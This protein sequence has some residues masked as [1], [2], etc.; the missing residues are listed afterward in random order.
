MSGRT[1]YEILQVSPTASD[2]EIKAAYR[3]L[4]W[5]PTGSAN[6][7]E[8]KLINEAYATLSSPHRRATYDQALA[9]GTPVNPAPAIRPPA[10]PPVT[11]TEPLPKGPLPLRLWG[12]VTGWVWGLSR[13]RYYFIPIT[14]VFGV[15]LIG[16]FFFLLSE[17]E[18][19]TNQPTP[20]RTSISILV[21]G[22]P[23]HRY[24]TVAGIPDYE[25]GYTVRG[26]D[27]ADYYV[28]HDGPQ[29][30]F[31]TGAKGRPEGNF[32]GLI[33]P[34]DS[35][36][37]N[38]I[39]KDAQNDGYWSGVRLLTT[40]YLDTTYQPKPPGVY[41]AG[42]GAVVLAL[43]L[44]IVP[45]IGRYTVFVARDGRDEEPAGG[46]VAWPVLVEATGKFRPVQGR[47]WRHF[48]AGALAQMVPGPEAGSGFKVLMWLIN[49]KNE[50]AYEIHI[51]A[52]SHVRVGVEY[53]GGRAT[54][55]LAVRAPG[56]TICLRLKSMAD[57][58]R[59]AQAISG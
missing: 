36:L 44:L 33:R 6:Q 43:L 15:F 2:E 51:P 11:E 32:T 53:T 21:R 49:G 42:M 41:M 26:R 55:A 28:L 24:I 27:A 40:H 50:K 46:E 34:L 47:G 13:A 48:H 1:L 58:H 52:G 56:Q 7:E 29:V 9:E 5:N 57:A 22:L 31:F 25:N 19:D 59:L 23:P 10:P 14:W 39:T 3:T 38:M 54:P 8:L 16:I 18:R 4:A 45:A 37:R 20:V 12:M 35:E 17:Y 30:I